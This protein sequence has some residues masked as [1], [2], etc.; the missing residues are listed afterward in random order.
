M[1]LTISFFSSPDEMMFSGFTNQWSILDLSILMVMEAYPQCPMSNAVGVKIVQSFDDL[2][3]NVMGMT[4]GIL[5]FVDQL[6][7]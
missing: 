1:S 3:D 7:K 6:D 2:F 4:L 5:S